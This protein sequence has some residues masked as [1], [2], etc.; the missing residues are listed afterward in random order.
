MFNFRLF[1]VLPTLMLLLHHPLKV[2]REAAIGCI[3]ALNDNN[4][5]KLD[6]G[7]KYLL[8]FIV[9]NDTEIVEDSQQICK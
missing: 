6:D 3:Q 7:L 1:T 8:K 4:R 2:V 9:A 5:I